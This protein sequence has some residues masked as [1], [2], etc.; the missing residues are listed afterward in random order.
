MLRAPKQKMNSVQEQ[1]S[2]VIRKM[3]MLKV[4]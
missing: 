4:H 2:N 3:E 1:M